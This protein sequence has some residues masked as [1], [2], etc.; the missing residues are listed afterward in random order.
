MFLVGVLFHLVMPLLF[1]GLIQQYANDS[2]F[3]PWVG[4]T[5]AY[6]ILHPFLFGL[7]V[8]AVYFGLHA[9]NP[10]LFRGLRGGMLFGLSVFIVGSLPVFAITF[11]SV[12]VSGVVI[13]SWVVRPG[14]I[15]SI[16]N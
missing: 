14:R 3:R 5:R 16:R 15:H 13:V 11:A 1:P 8:T 9:H 7:V 4:W 10:A 2:L 12:R 6:M